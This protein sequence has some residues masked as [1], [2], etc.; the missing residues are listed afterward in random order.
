MKTLARIAIIAAGVILVLSTAWIEPTATEVKWSKAIADTLKVIGASLVLAVVVFWLEQWVHK[1]LRKGAKVSL[2]TAD[3][4]CDAL[5]KAVSEHQSNDL[6]T[7]R[8][9]SRSIGNADKS[10]A[11]IAALDSR[12]YSKTSDVYRIV[13]LDNEQKLSHVKDLINKHWKNDRFAIKALDPNAGIRLVDLV[14]VDNHFVCLGIET[15]TPEE[16]Y[17]VRIDDDDIAIHFRKYFFESHWNR[18]EAR[19]IK[20]LRA[21]DTEEGKNAAIQ[22]VEE[23]YHEIH[24]A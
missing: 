14:C 21:L 22:K 15:R 6:F 23:M 4:R 10:K 3:K 13:T 11:Y 24:G 7:T 5:K 17:W 9:S 1:E 18:D 20:P 19:E 2:I 16:N 12:I 8:Y